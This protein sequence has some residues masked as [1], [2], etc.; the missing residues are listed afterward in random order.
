MIK[1]GN[2]IVANLS[3]KDFKVKFYQH[4]FFTHMWFS[5]NHSNVKAAGDFYL[6]IP[7]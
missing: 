3:Q 5:L 2:F 6:Y 7:S 1:G 4:V